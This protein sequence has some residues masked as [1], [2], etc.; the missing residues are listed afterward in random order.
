M[1]LILYYNIL[2]S[3]IID[4]LRDS[5]NFF[6]NVYQVT[7]DFTNV[8]ELPLFKSNVLNFMGDL[9]KLK[10]IFNKKFEKFQKLKKIWKKKNKKRTQKSENN[11]K[12]Q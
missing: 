5:F 10:I 2:Y 4:E 1:F 3:I 7:C 8:K 11:T 6:K 12:K 9:K